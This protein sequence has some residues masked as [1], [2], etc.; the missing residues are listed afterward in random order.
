MEN[1]HRCFTSKLIFVIVAILSLVCLTAC[2]G[3]Q[4]SSFSIVGEWNVDSY[5]FDGKVVQPGD[6]WEYIGLNTARIY[7]DRKIT[8]FDDKTFVMTWPDYDFGKHMDDIYGDYTIADSTLKLSNEEDEYLILSIQ[9]N[10]ILWD[11][12][13]TG[14]IIRYK[15]N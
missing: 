5:V 9:D 6:A 11:A 4:D 7:N 12:E 3:R 8:F 10:L 2:S 15:K 1:M 14:Y 13:N